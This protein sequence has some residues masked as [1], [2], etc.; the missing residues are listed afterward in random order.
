MRVLRWLGLAAALGLALAWAAPALWVAWALPGLAERAGGA[1]AL[2]GVRPVFPFGVSVGRA[3]L[4]RDGRTL[5]LA[6]LAARALP[7]GVRVDA[8]VGAGTLLV[9]T[10]GL[11]VGTGFVRAESLPLEALDGFLASGLS[12]RGTA[13]GVYRFGARS[14]LEANVRQG[15]V[16][17]RAPAGIELP[18][19]QLTLAAAREPDGAWSIAFA[20]LRG[21]PLSATARGEIGADGRLALRAEIAELAEPA[22]SGFALLELPTGPLPYTARIDGTLSRP[23]FARVEAPAQ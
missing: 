6:D 12:L 20:D 8:R 9:R 23:R 17:L 13:D 16:V 15:A 10:E 7:G 4:T 2:E 18:F 19:A 11:S 5:D 21:P 22:L 1:I 3:R 14:E